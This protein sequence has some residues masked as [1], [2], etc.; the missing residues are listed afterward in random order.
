MLRR[1]L[2]YKQNIISKEWQT[3]YNVLNNKEWLDHLLN[4]N[5]LKEEHKQGY[6]YWQKIEVTK[7]S[8]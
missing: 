1:A 7:L 8:R 3:I 4:N 5:Y 6:D 2:M